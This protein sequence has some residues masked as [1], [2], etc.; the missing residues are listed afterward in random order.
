MP[1]S[2]FPPQ[3]PL[4]FLHYISI[5]LQKHNKSTDTLPWKCK[6]SFYGRFSQ[7]RGLKTI[8]Y[9]SAK[10]SF[11][12]LPL[13]G[14]AF[15]SFAILLLT[16]PLCKGSC[17]Q[18]RLRDCNTTSL[19]CSYEMIVCT[20]FL[21]P[22]NTRRLP[23]PGETFLSFAILLLTAPLCKGKVFYSVA[24]INCDKMRKC[25]KNKGNASFFGHSL[26]F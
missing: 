3:K 4:L 11:W 1:F 24:M 16:A 7:H 8:C 2:A 26:I 20:T 19:Y 23:L 12:H 25:K 17:R 10:T 9:P 22:T 14:E 21:C 15:L 13:P 5:I 6:K 18:R